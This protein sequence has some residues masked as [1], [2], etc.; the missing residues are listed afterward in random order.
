MVDL[1]KATIDD[2]AQTPVLLFCG[3]ASPLPEDKAGQ[4][5]LAAKLRGYLD[6]GGFLFAE[7]YCQGSDFDQGFRQLMKLVFPEPEYTL[8]LLPPEHPIWFAE[9]QV[10]P[11]YL[12][13][14]EGIDF[15]CRTSVVYAPLGPS[16]ARTLRFPA[17][18]SLRGPARTPAS[19][20]G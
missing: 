20:F 16:G 9:Q 19:R 3:S 4:Q 10:D 18:G 6:R 1:R 8:R 13:A 15:G 17:C 12:Q 11:K 7:A 2:L 5:A 14:L